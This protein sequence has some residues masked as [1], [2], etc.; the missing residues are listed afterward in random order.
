[1]NTIRQI[2]S[3]LVCVCVPVSSVS[4]HS[5]LIWAQKFEADGV[6]RKNKDY[7]APY[8]SVSPSVR[9]MFGKKK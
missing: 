9:E 8:N 1:M 3:S 4:S 7:H 5:L 6:T 2:K